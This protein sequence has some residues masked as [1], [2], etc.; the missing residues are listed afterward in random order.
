MCRCLVLDCIVGLNLAQCLHDV[1]R[2][3]GGDEDFATDYAAALWLEQGRQ[4]T[5][6]IAL[7]QA[8]AAAFGERRE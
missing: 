6:A 4:K 5:A 1:G 3:V 2:L 8:I 7:N